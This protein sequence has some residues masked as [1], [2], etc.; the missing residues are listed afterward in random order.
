MPALVCFLDCFFP[1][2]FYLLSLWDTFRN[3][4]PR[5]FF[6][7]PAIL[8]NQPLE[9][10]LDWEILGWEILDWEI[11]EWCPVALELRASCQRK[12]ECVGSGQGLWWSPQ[13]L[14]ELV[15]AHGCF[16]FLHPS[17]KSG[18]QQDRDSKNQWGDNTSH[19]QSCPWCLPCLR[20]RLLK[21]SGV[22]CDSIPLEHPCCWG[23]PPALPGDGRGGGW[24]CSSPGLWQPGSLHCLLPYA[25]PLHLMFLFLNGRKSVLTKCWPRIY[26]TL[27]S[28]YDP[29]C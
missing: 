6:F 25:V 3:L 7:P 16:T 29:V 12:G 17:G 26:L 21:G 2:M 9:G 20:S 8:E 10:V 22:E 27:I 23:M 28:L 19:L 18:N 4:I 13:F 5:D 1:Q 15:T 11:L 24:P 14:M